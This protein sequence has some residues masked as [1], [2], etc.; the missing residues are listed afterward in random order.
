MKKELFD[1]LR[2][3]FSVILF[4]FLS[5]ILIFVFFHFQLVVN[6]EI[7]YEMTESENDSEIVKFENEEESGGEGKEN[8]ESVENPIDKSKVLS[9]NKLIELTNLERENKNLKP[10][11]TDQNLNNIAYQKAKDILDR[12]YFA[13]ISPTG[14][15]AADLAERYGY[16]Y[17]L[18][19]ENLAKGIFADNQE[20]IEGWMNSPPHRENILKPGY[21]EIGIAIRKGDYQGDKVWVGVQIF[22]TPTSSCP[23]VDEQLLAKIKDYEELMSRLITEIDDLKSEIEE[24]R[25][26][27][28]IDQYNKLVN[29]YN[30]LKEEIDVKINEY[31][32]QV[33]E[34]NNCFNNYN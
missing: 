32:D 20:I 23:Q 11:K 5:S 19:G 10:L 7:N 18:I 30:D 29:T 4:L 26:S 34:R 17:L 2:K 6:P 9:R 25:S 3:L 16:E 8:N 27:D 33:E 22:A 14:E 15:G 21:E 24:N 31:N 12:E 28:K 1:F 13:H